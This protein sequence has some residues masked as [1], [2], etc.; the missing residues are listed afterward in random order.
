[1]INRGIGRFIYLSVVVEYEDKMGLKKDIC[2]IKK[3]ADGIRFN[4][5]V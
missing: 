3:G 2:K 5:G 4:F 1:M